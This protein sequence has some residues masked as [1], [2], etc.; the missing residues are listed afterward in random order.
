MALA[1]I[2]YMIRSRSKGKAHTGRAHC[3]LSSANRQRSLGWMIK[4][5][6][7]SGCDSLSKK[8]W[9]RSEACGILFGE[10]GDLVYE[11]LAKRPVTYGW[12]ALSWSG[13]TLVH[14][15]TV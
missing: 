13:A 9:P 14:D 4:I 15:L 7:V 10:D 12:R 6:G 2:T 1:V 8:R 11:V 3:E 5:T